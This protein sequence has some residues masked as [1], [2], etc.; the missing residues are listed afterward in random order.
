MLCPALSVI[1]SVRSLNVNPLEALAD[2]IV[3][4]AP[5]ELLSDPVID[6]DEPRATVPKLKLGGFAVSCPSATP[7]PLTTRDVV[8]F[9][10][11]LWKEMVPENDPAEEG[12]NLRL[13]ATLCPAAIVTGSE[14]PESVKAE[15]VLDA[16]AMV[17]AAP[18]AAKVPEAVD[19][20]PALT[21]P[22]L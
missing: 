14:R 15:S 3:T 2:E 21:L 11:L 16:D 1:G 6:F 5:P 8:A 19:E 17:T 10:A 12:A 18:V 20:A 9:A 13:K 22:K 4:A 7:V